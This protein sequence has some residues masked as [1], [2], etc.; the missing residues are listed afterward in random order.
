M[1]NIECKIDESQI[2][3]PGEKLKESKKK[4]KMPSKQNKSGRDWGRGM[5]CVGRSKEC[6]IVPKNHFGPIPGIEVGTRWRYRFQVSFLT[7]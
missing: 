4:E 2:V 7:S 3:K 1:K 6:T 5:A